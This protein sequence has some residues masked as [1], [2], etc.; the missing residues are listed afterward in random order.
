MAKTTKTATK[1]AIKLD[2]NSLFTAE[3][4]I[5]KAIESIKRRGASLQAD[6]HKVACSI[7]LHLGKHQDVRVLR[8]FLEAVPEM[9]R[10]N[11][12]RQWFETFGPVSY[13][14]GKAVYDREKKV[15]LGNAIEKPFWRFK[16]NEGTP[17]VPLMDQYFKNQI[18]K[19]E[20]DQRETKRDH[21]AL[22]A[23][24]KVAAET[25]KAPEQAAMN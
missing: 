4:D 16:A 8:R 5:N 24:L 20:K 10:A 19:L 23:A 22:I 7:L 18:S 2:A 17:Y 12:L 3:A 21:S 1:P 25:Y 6:M 14:G 9:S 13:E 15:R 11:A